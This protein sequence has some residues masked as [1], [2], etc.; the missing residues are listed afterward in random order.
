M[1]YRRSALSAAAAVFLTA[2]AI[3]LGGCGQKEETPAQAE[4]Q[5]GIVDMETLIK[6]H[7]RYSEYY[8]L[9]TEYDSM[10]SEYKNEQNRLIQVSSQ[11][12]QAVRR[13]AS[14]PAIDE[15]LNTE[16]Q[17]RMQ[18]KEDELNAGLKAHYDEV[19]KKY[20][21]T[22]SVPETAA[23]SQDEGTRIA[24]LQM[25]ILILDASGEE[26]EKAQ[27]ELAELLNQKTPAV[28][29]ASSSENSLSEADAKDL[30]S[31]K[32][33]AQQE[34]SSYAQSL[35]EEL[36]ARRTAQQQ[37]AAQA[38]QDSAQLPSPEIWNEDWQN[39]LKA[40]QKEMDD[41]KESIMKDIREKAAVVAQQKNLTMIFSSYRV[42]LHAVDVTGD[43]VSE[44]MHMQ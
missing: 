41:V 42:N 38:A 24:N 37:A 43:I 26:K 29:M 40:K 5:Y 34:L 31:R 1:N 6:A 3:F 32:Q 28:S 39:K 20:S 27:K 11:Q 19:M 15:A 23:I 14:D 44:I 33:A 10:R 9:E 12:E 2:S 36:S 8:K 22:S 13:A 17:S 25:K 16:Y 21:H 35:S 30:A 7:P 18:Q 4:E